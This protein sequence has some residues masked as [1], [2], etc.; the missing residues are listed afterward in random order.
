VK[1]S[2]RATWQGRAG[3]SSG[4]RCCSHASRRARGRSSPSRSKGKTRIRTATTCAFHQ[5]DRSLRIGSECSYGIAD[6]YV[7]TNARGDVT[8]I[9]YVCA[10]GGTGGF[11]TD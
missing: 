2:G 6:V 10:A 1:S 8:R 7:E 9:Q 4:E 5:Y 3:I 11:P